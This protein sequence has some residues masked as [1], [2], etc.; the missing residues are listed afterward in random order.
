MRRSVCAP[1]KSF[2]QKITQ[3]ICF[4]YR[5][6]F[7]LRKLKTKPLWICLGLP[8]IQYFSALSRNSSKRPCSFRPHKV[9]AQS[10][11]HSSN[12]SFGPRK[13]LKCLKC[14]S[15]VDNSEVWKYILIS[16]GW[17]LN[18]HMLAT[19]PSLSAM[20][21]RTE[22]NSLYSLDCRKLR[23]R[24]FTS[25]QR[26]ENIRWNHVKIMW[27]SCENPP[28]LPCLTTVFARMSLSSAYQSQLRL[29]SVELPQREW[30]SVHH[31]RLGAIHA[32]HPLSNVSPIN[33]T[34]MGTM[35]RR[36]RCQ[37]CHVTL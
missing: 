32:C 15:K 11:K 6:S 36:W 21:F 18:V 5:K 1:K 28:I 33:G 34:T 16:L 3:R 2:D 22:S 25:M 35:V 31:P 12:F 19:S 29:S 23:S 26:V 8:W 14:K 17:I 37:Q 10:F 9:C 7:N 13:A 30:L 24:G 27:K 4:G 20:P